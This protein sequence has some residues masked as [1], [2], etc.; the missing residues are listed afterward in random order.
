MFIGA[1]NK[2]KHNKNNVKF[3]YKT[4]SKSFEY[5]AMIISVIID[6]I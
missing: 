5:T 4:Y 1:Y 3:L 2:S 6:M